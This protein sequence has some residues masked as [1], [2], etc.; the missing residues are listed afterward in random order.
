MKFSIIT[1]TYNRAHIISSTIQSVLSQSY[2]NFEHIIIDDGSTDNTKEIIDSFRD[3][4]LRYF[5]YDKQEKRSYLRNQGLKKAAGDVICIL[6]SDDIWMKEK[7]EVLSNIF[8]SEK[9]ATIIFHNVIEINAA[10]KERKLY[11][12]IEDVYL[13]G[14][15][16]I[17]KNKLLP[18]PF[19]SFKKSILQSVK[20]YNEETIDGQQDFLLRISTK[21]RFYFC[22]KV[23]ATKIE[24]KEN[25]SQIKQVNQLIDYK[26]SIDFLLK[27]KHITRKQHLRTLQE[28]NFKIARIYANKKNKKLAFKYILIILKEPPFLSVNYF[29]T[30]LLLFKVILRF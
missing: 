13:D 15:K 20:S 24:H 21:Y 16:E 5:Y 26:K 28:I 2:T 10:K 27:N 18:F 23:L 3:D 22:S 12:Y 4:R 9:E 30:V 25:L 14:T 7:L 19:Y 11:N 17:L 8:T 1:I 6:D 29:K